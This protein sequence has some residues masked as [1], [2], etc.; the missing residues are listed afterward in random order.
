MTIWL[1]I[2]HILFLSILPWAAVH[3][4]CFI[5][6]FPILLFDQLRYVF[7]RNRNIFL[8]RLEKVLPGSLQAMAYRIALFEFNKGLL[9]CDD[10]LGST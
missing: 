1:Q 2:W 3:S 7:L 6:L 8:I 10:L 9:L 5:Y 4:L